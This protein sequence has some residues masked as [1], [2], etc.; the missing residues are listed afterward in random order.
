MRRSALTD[1]TAQAL[2]LAVLAA[3]L[4][5]VVLALGAIGAALLV[6]ARSAL[7]KAAAAAALAAL[8]QATVTLQLQVTYV[9]YEC[10]QGGVCTAEPGQ[11]AVS[12]SDGGSFA[13][14]PAGLFG[15]LPGWAAA[16]GCAG[17][18]WSGAP[19]AAGTYRIC[20]SQRPVGG[21]L[22]LPP[23]AALRQTAQQWLSAAAQTSGDIADA[24]VTA[25][26][27]GTA[28]Q[29]TVEAAADV[30]PALW[31]FRSVHAAATAWPGA[32]S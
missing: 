22:D 25:V 26:S 7:S 18:V 23:P 32:P 5:L 29:V 28:E 16:A 20:T 11:E 2:V 1:E 6:S 3:G 19:Q 21:A 31:V 8:E 30:R 4:C 24:H 14:G 13:A 15:S 27:I 9:D 10:D 12:V 17:T